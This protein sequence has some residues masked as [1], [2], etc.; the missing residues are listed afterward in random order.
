[1]Q[2]TFTNAT[3]GWWQ[4]ARN[5]PDTSRLG[6]CEALYRVTRPMFVVYF[7]GQTAVCQDG[8]ISIGSRIPPA[9]DSLPLVGY[10]PA[11][12]P[13]DLGDPEFKKSHNLRY[14]YVVG[15]MANGITSVEMVQAAG[16]GGLIGFFGAAGLLPAEIDAA[17]SRLQDSM[18]SRPF[19]FNL[20]HSPTDPAL[21][22]AAVDLYLRRG[23]KLVS[24]SAYLDLTFPLVYF[25]V[26]GI[27]RDSTGKIVCPH[28][29]IAKVSRV[30]VAKKFFSPPPEKY[31]RQL[32]DQRLISAE[33][34][35]MASEIP[36]ADDLTAEADSG[37]HTDNR[38][39]LTLL[40]TM[41]A[42]R[43]EM[44]T[45]YNFRHPLRI[46]L[47]GGIAT[48]QAAA[49]AFALGAAYVLTGSINQACIESGTSGTVRQMLAEAD[50]ADVCMAP[51]ADMFELGVKV[52]VLKRGTMFPLR[53][54]KLYDLYCRHNCYE[55][56]PGDQRK[57]LER[58]FFKCSFLEEW[59][60]TKQFFARRDPKQIELA[61]NKPKHKMAL[62]FRSYLGR[63]SNWANSGDPS[64]KIDYQIWCGPAMGAFNHWV[65]GTFLEKSENRSTVTVA[66]NL[67][68]G[69]AVATRLN[70][71]RYQ[72]VSL[73]GEAVKIQP[74]E[75]A[76]IAGY[77]DE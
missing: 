65:R 10:A 60:Q 72:G 13:K 18:G 23:I 51:S 43:D 61:E 15:A 8:T 76:K 16:R 62:V 38:P 25:R 24:A 49:A 44:A 20:I 48:P 29:I 59:Q 9:S 6:L 39:A 34:A 42:L 66:L 32:L 28:K 71:L 77:L 4:P 47:A 74:L 40:P 1:M 55:E 27:Y 35:A 22:S 21:E 26:N 64:R 30:E 36:M 14:A 2:P 75:S 45:V 69:A 3:L 73:P 11:L 19:G 33:Q 12:H 37:G 7:N 53:A 58:D 46:G 70:W 54:A 17:I 5:L 31:L 56:I 63:S 41:L 50:Q 52:Q 67:L 57:N 68:F